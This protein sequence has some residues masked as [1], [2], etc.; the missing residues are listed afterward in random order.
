MTKKLLMVCYYFPPLLDVG[1][2][3]SVAF[4]KYL[5]TQGWSP[6]ILS[7]RN[8]DRFY[9]H[10]GD[11]KL[12]DDSVLYVW[13]LINCYWFLGKFNG[14][15][16]RILGLFGKGTKRNY[17]LDVF[18]IPDIFIGWIPG[19]I[20]GG[21]Y[22]CKRHK[23]EYIYISCSP[24]SSAIAGIV[25]KWLTGKSLI[26]DFR[27]PFAIN[28]P[29]SLNVPRVR[30]R[31]NTW[32]EKKIIVSADLF[33]VN[34]REVY[35]GYV[36]VYPNISSKT[37]VIYNGFDH[38]SLPVGIIEKFNKFSITY[39]GNM[40]LTVPGS[41]NIFMAMSTLKKQRK[42]DSSNFQFLYFGNDRDTICDLAIQYGVADLVDAKQPVVHTEMLRILK[43]SHLQLL[44]IMKPMI[45]TKLFEGI[46]LNV[47]FL[48][49]IPQGEVAEIIL[50]FS[51]SSYIVPENSP[52]LIVAAIDKAMIAYQDGKV[53]DNHVPKFLQQYSRE[54]MTAKLVEE[55]EKL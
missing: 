9:C 8:P 50:A 23:I 34:S 38:Q 44:R 5:K 35:D 45:S 3:R 6:Y 11:K 17:F 19:A 47:P 54:S 41:E 48:A 1:C 30:R 16:N 43:K 7:V 55:I 13:S 49:T 15:L 40:Y 14:L 22:L 12:S 27:D 18:C 4:A 36:R 32:I 51:P 53:Q 26:I 20:L 10:L 25:L 29:A 33:V 42:I 39:G 37:V 21:W 46:A 28:V 2:K 31:I 52:E 24:F